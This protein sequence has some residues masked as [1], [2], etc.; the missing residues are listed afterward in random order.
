MSSARKKQAPAG[1]IERVAFRE[2]R[3]LPESVFVVER[4]IERVGHG[5]ELGS[6]SY[7]KS[8]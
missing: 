4:W 2:E 1:R 8:R 5:A 6:V 7:L 3:V